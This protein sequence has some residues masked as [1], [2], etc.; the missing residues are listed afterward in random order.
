MRRPRTRPEAPPRGRRKKRQRSNL[1][2][3]KLDVLPVRAGSKMS[4][5]NGGIPAVKKDEVTR[6]TNEGKSV[7]L[8]GLL[9]TDLLL[10]STLE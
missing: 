1:A 6:R 9:F 4:G 8:F 7:I 3:P 10:N 5:A 2:L